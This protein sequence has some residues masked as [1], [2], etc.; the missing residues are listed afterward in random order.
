MVHGAS[1]DD[2]AEV[3][4]QAAGT[5]DGTAATLAHAHCGTGGILALGR[6]GPRP[7]LRR[8]HEW[9]GLA[10]LPPG[11]RSPV[12]DG[13][14]PSQP[15]KPSALAPNDAT[16]H[17]VASDSSYLPSLSPRATGRPYPRREPDAVMPH[18]RICGGGH[19]RSLIPTPT[20]VQVNCDHL[21]YCSSVTCSIHSTA[22][23]LSSSCI[24]MCVIA[25]FGVAPCQC[26]TP[27]GIQITSP[28]RIS[29]I[30]PPHC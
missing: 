27:A 20:A 1:A 25:V 28:F 16:G 4:S 26:F 21:W 17:P 11:C 30:G 18:V 9:P 29:S 3:A 24:A 23:P 13:V 2:A 14:A 5:E 22:L 8:T 12:V 15:R 10:C 7:L 19:A 6:I